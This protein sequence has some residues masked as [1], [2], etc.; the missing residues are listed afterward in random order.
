M[1]FYIVNPWKTKKISLK[2]EKIFTKRSNW[3]K[4]LANIC[5]VQHIF[6]LIQGKFYEGG[7]GGR[8]SI[9]RMCAK[10]VAS[11][12]KSNENNKNCSIYFL[13]LYTNNACNCSCVH[14]KTE[15]EHMKNRWTHAYHS[16]NRWTNSN[17]WSR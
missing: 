8:R 10:L 13:K 7:G 1:T 4:I 9:S 16:N 12:L 17:F 6:N 5:I 15:N 3:I 11:F 14:P 2:N